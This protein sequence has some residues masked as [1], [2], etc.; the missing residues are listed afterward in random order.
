MHLLH[1]VT[2]CYWKSKLAVSGVSPLRSDCCPVLGR[3][4]AQ[5]RSYLRPC[6][7]GWVKIFIES[8]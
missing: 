5:Q 2:T 1:D 3:I 6:D 4:L 7:I 8:K